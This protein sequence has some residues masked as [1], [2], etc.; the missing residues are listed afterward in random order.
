MQHSDDH[1]IHDVCLYNLRTCVFLNVNVLF[2]DY[3]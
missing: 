1:D 2:L 3:A